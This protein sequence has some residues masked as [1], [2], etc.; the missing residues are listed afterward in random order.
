M[1]FKLL[2]FIALFY[3]F[4]SLLSNSSFRDFLQTLLPQTKEESIENQEEIQELGIKEHFALA[5]GDLENE[6]IAQNLQKISLKKYLEEE[7]GVSFEEG[8]E[9]EHLLYS[10]HQIWKVGNLQ[11]FFRYPHFHQYLSVR[12]MVAF[13]S[14]RFTELL[15]QAL[16]LEFIEEEE[17]WGF[18]FLNA[19]R[20]QESYES[21]EDF[22]D[23]YFRGLTIINYRQLKRS[24]DFDFEK[25]LEKLKNASKVKVLWLKEEI[26]SD[27]KVIETI[28]E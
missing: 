15:R 21:W 5:L 12:D 1:L 22:R 20:V 17:A 6:R 8:K 27:I 13:D 4:R 25:E 2:F 10:L 28:K 24:E 16:Y 3:I 26:F 11:L 9:K 19:Q 7:H 23:A 18:L 14:A